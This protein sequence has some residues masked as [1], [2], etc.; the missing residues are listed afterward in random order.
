M[1]SESKEVVSYLLQEINIWNKQGRNTAL[2][3]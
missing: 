3:W 2:K 1:P